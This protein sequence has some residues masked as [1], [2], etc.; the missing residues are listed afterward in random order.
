MANIKK[1]NEY[2][3]DGNEYNFIILP[4]NIGNGDVMEKIR[5]HINRAA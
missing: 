2:I 3:V 1:G 5:G 4:V